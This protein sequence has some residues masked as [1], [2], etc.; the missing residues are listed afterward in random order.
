MFDRSPKE[1]EVM[2]WGYAVFWAGLTFVTV[3]YV[4][5][6]VDFVSEYLGP[7]FFTYAAAALVVLAA[8]SA[9][10]IVRQRLTLS[11]CI[12][13]MA[14]AGLIVYLVVG[15]ADGSA[16]EAVHYV[17]Y[18]TLS[19]L[20][21]RAFSHRVRD[22]SIYVAVTITGTLVG[23]M[24]ETVQWLTPD[25][26]F[27][28]RDIWLNFT[29][30]AFVQIG[31]AAGIRPK[32]ISGFPNWEGLRRICCL[33][34]LTVGY[35]GLCL[36][37]TPDRI[38]WYTANVSWLEFVDPSR[39]IMVEYGHLHG[40]EANV[41]F[42]SRLNLEE[43]RQSVSSHG[44]EQT[45][46][47]DDIHERESQGDF[48]IRDYLLAKPYLYEGRIHQ[49]RRDI[50]LKRATSSDEDEKKAQN[51][52]AAY[53]NNSI[54]KDYFYG[55]LHD[56]R[57]EWSPEME[58][59]VRDSADLTM[60]YESDVSEHLIVAYSPRRLAFLSSAAVVALLLLACV[61]RMAS[62]RVSAP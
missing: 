2:S 11:S 54:L 52:A 55:L 53:W 46:N 41:V 8:A 4:R 17:Q 23:M 20:L 48:Q 29:G 1:K 10:Y 37:N 47:L 56:T 27:D 44:E 43:L 24:D 62:R 5:V 58:V 34:A 16:V 57:Y 51:F 49:L 14:I 36:Q 59:E 25:R 21:F 30:V 38:A 9:L 12:W 45:L 35:L 26:V 31:L 61:F 6:S 50:Y 18:G 32:V 22:Y 39:N 28:L 3:P 42:H 7:G 13:V 15:L 40:D 60:S 19:L 33:S